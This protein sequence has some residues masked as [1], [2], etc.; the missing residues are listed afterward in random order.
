MNR[1]LTSGKTAIAAAAVFV[2][3][4]LVTLSLSRSHGGNSVQSAAAA[5]SAR[6]D[7]S[8][9]ASPRALLSVVRGAAPAGDDIRV[10]TMEGR[11]IGDPLKPG[12]WTTAA[13]PLRGRARAA[14]ALELSQPG[15]D[16]GGLGFAQAAAIV[17]GVLVLL[18]LMLAF[19]AA[20]AREARARGRGRHPDRGPDLG[21]ARPP[22]EPAGSDAERRL[23]VG[24]LMVVI[25][26]LPDSPAGARAARALK[27]VGVETIEPQPGVVFNP[28]LH[29]VCG[30]VEAPEPSLIDSVAAVVRPGYV[31]HGLVLREADV[32]IYGGTRATT[33][34]IPAVS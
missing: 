20:A 5:L 25:D 27:Q 8:G 30:V 14:A 26:T 10:V 16:G 29:C 15:V 11:L 7:A 13:Y 31:D 32:Q 19:G 23:L 6:G 21:S 18:A 34:A 3:I 28:R 1:R 12:L 2:A 9:A 33:G 4:G 22:V 17:A 24:A